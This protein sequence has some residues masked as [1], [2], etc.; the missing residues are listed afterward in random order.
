MVETA[1]GL[2]YWRKR[3]GDVQL[4]VLSAPQAL[5]AMLM[6][7]V[8]LQTL[9]Q[10]LEADL[11]LAVEVMVVAV[12]LPQLDGDVQGLQHALNMLGSER[13]QAV[14][15][16]RSKRPF[17]PEKPAHLALAQAVSV[18]R[19]AVM[20]IN[21][22]ES[23]E[24]GSASS[25]LVGVALMLGLTRWRLACAA[26]EVATKIEARVDTGERRAEV[27]RQLLGCSIDE[28]NRALL[29]DAGFSRDAGLLN[30]VLPT[31]KMLSQAAR[32]AWTGHLA[33]EL[34]AEL[35]RGLRLRTTNALLAHLIAWSAHDDW[36]GPRTGLLER[37]FSSA[38]TLPLDSFVANLHQLAASASRSF[39]LREQ[40]VSAAERLF[41]PPKPPRSLIQRPKPGASEAFAMS[42]TVRRKVDAE[43]EIIARPL[44]RR[45][46]TGA[47]APTT[48]GY[49][50][51]ART[52]DGFEPRGELARP[53]RK[54]GLDDP[55]RG[56]DAP[57]MARADE[58]SDAARAPAVS[59]DPALV[60]MYA[61]NCQAGTYQD[62]KQLVQ[63]TRLVLENGLG[64]SRCLLFL[65]LAQAEE[66]GCYLAHGFD[67]RLDPR[68]LTI[69]VSENNLIARI[70]RQSG[71]LWVDRARVEAARPQ[72]P[73]LLRE[74]IQREGFMMSGLKM[75]DRPLGALW[76][77]GGETALVLNEQLYDRF[78]VMAQQFGVAFTAIARARKR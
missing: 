75:N 20:L 54:S 50:G 44:A 53:L 7:S 4:P 2:D 16:A 22:L 18:S 30:T 31:G 17:N 64:L 41:W 61:K 77:D 32:Y 33:P 24:L 71:A 19:L 11:P 55:V 66:L 67:A 1:G 45:G 5:E 60:D 28:L 56:E 34:P 68:R 9:G 52:A 70:F 25:Y 37:V 29:L 62:L 48:P 15:R 13:V 59:A 27:E 3:L 38:N 72:L 40:V 35:A 6:P 39:V 74:L 58:G 51:P 49:G 12:R 23:S 76:A 73:D 65:K 63:A 36:Y 57:V 10:Y 14:V 42:T 78:R 26:P 43:G 21:T 47:E 8:S 69:V 46:D